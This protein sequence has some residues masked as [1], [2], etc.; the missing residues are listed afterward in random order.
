MRRL[1]DSGE[2]T[3]ECRDELA[4]M[5]R[6]YVPPAQS[7]VVWADA[8]LIGMN[9]SIAGVAKNPADATAYGRH[10]ATLTKEILK[11]D[12]SPSQIRNPKS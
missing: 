1:T 3:P 2:D 8:V 7:D 6:E 4:R 10:I 12:E 5:R 11:S 9:G